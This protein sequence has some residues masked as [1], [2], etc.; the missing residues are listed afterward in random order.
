MSDSSLRPHLPPEEIA[1]R[2]RWV[3][4]GVAVLSLLLVATWLYGLPSRL[5]AMIGSSSSVFGDIPQANYIDAKEYIGTAIDDQQAKKIIE[6]LQ[7]TDAARGTA[8]AA[9]P[10]STSTLELMKKKLK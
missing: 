8:V 3:I 6:S 9:Q 10:L 1:R 7:K 4:V 2:Q 5:G